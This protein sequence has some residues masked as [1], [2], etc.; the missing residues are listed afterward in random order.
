MHVIPKAD[1][2]DV[3]ALDEA[4]GLTLLHR[5]CRQFG[6][7]GTMFT[8]EDLRSALEAAGYDGTDAE[9]QKLANTW[10]VRKGL[11]DALVSIGWDWIHAGVDE[12]FGG[13][14]A[15]NVP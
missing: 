4:T 11:T 3:S 1:D 10:Q 7:Q 13:T 14:T 6:W 8:T 2:F 9:V 5:L 15:G 12:A